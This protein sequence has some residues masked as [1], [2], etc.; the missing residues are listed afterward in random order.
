VPSG[1]ALTSNNSALPPGLGVRDHALPFQRRMSVRSVGDIVSQA[2]MHDSPAA[3]AVPPGPA[4]MPFRSARPGLGLA[5]WAQV[6]PFQRKISVRSADVGFM[7]HPAPQDMPAA[8]TAEADEAAM[9]LS[10]L[11]VAADGDSVP[12]GLGTVT[13]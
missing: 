10:Q 12:R 2:E 13:G 1:A 8:H 7:A 11:L 9:L 4:L 5:A 6:A 3:Q